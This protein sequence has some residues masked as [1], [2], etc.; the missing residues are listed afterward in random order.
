MV[1]LILS[2]SLFFI[3]SPSPSLWIS[4]LHSILY[5]LNKEQKGDYMGIFIHKYTCT[6]QTGEIACC[7]ESHIMLHFERDLCWFFQGYHQITVSC[8]HFNT[9]FRPSHIATDEWVA[10]G[11]SQ[12]NVLPYSIFRFLNMT[13]QTCNKS[14]SKTTH[15]CIYLH[16][17]SPS[18]S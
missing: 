17:S 10:W 6:W 15:T 13:L 3:T 1:A 5:F 14:L 4:L 16:K 12:I 18:S 8:I 7:R 2:W 9:D 11:R